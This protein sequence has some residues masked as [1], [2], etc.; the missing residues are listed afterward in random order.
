MSSIKIKDLPEKTDNLDDNDLMVVEDSED[1][2]KISL[3]RLRSIFSMDG[4]LTSMKEMLLKQINDFME[5]HS[6]KYKELLSRNEDLEV[7]C[8]NLQNDHDH[9]AARIFELEN[10]LVIE[11][12]NVS[13]LLSEKNRLLSILTE[14]ERQETILSEKIIALNDKITQDSASIAI[15]KSQVKDLQLKSKELKSIG[16]ELQNLIDKLEKDSGDKINENFTDIQNALSKAIEDLMAY[17]RYYHPDV[18]NLNLEVVD[19]G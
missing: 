13:D 17:I 10:K 16:E 8:H 4:I 12:Q 6:T 18:D 5:K 14:L 9:D 3:I 1:T 19:N 15:L 7:I 2:K 11:Q